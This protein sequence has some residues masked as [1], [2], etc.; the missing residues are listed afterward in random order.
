MTATPREIWERALE[1]HRT[2]DIEGYAGTF[3]EDAVIEIPFHPPSIPERI[4]GRAGILQVLGPFWR[5]ARESSRRIGGLDRVVVHETADPEV[6]VVEFDVIGTDAGIPFRLSYVHVVR[7]KGGLI[8]HLR[9]YVDSAAIADRVR[10]HAA[11][12]G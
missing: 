1:S 2:S 11:A 12:S 4:E 8:V 6:I 5:R 3:A 7:A 10:K 9:D